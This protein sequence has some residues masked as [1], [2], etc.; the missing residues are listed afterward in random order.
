VRAWG[1]GV[2]SARNRVAHEGLPEVRFCSRAT[3]DETIA[4]GLKVPCS[5]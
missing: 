3:R 4:L 5:Y 1:G 2:F